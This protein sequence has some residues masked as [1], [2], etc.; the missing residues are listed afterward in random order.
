M[1]DHP[2]KQY[3]L[4]KD[5]EEQVAARK[6]P[7]VPEVLND[8]PHA[9]AY[10]GAIRLVVGDRVDAGQETDFVAEARAIDGCVKTADAENSLNPQN[11]EAA[12]RK[13]LLPRLF[14][15]LGL[16][17]AKAVIDQVVHITRLGLG[18]G[19]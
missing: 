14:T 6:T 8:E 12:I 4:F 19:A 11:I 7:G 17:A 2:L 1:F 5:F 18:R 3:A 16:E 10:Y 13:A 15:Q 9:K